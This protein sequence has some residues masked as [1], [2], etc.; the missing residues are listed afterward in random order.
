MGGVI[1]R[2]PSADE[3]GRV[4]AQI[5]ESFK[6]AYAGMMTQSYL[7]SLPPDHWVPILQKG[8]AKGNTC[9]IAEEDG[10]VLGTVVYGKSESEPGGADWHA[11]Y[12]SP[13]RIGQG[14]GHRLYAYMEET[15]RSQGFRRCTLE[16]LTA[17]HRAVKFYEDHGYALTGTFTV[18]ENGMELE[19]C[20]MKK[21]FS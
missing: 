13:Q 15:M 11:I 10:R 21:Q 1:F 4:S 16:A 3:L 9:I 2:M 8:L 6:A 18:R 5:A 20:T 19:C 7:D 14:L 12:L 17:N